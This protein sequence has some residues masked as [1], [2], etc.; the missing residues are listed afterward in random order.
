MFSGW[1]RSLGLVPFATFRVGPAPVSTGV[2]ALTS[3]L[4]MTS[5]EQLIHAF[6]LPERQ[7]RLLAL[8]SSPKQR[9][10]LTAGLAHFRALDPRFATQIAPAE[11]DA[12]TIEGLLRKRG[13]QEICHVLSENSALDARELPLREALQAVVGRGMGTFLSCIPGR[14]GYFESE[15]PGERYILERTAP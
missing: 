7:D 12:A 6:V 13:A 5:E 4:I 3:T 11:Q 15:E 2:R 9:R 1:F 10:K 8:L 14:L